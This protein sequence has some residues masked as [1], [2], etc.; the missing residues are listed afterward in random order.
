MKF[1][2]MKKYHC[3]ARRPAVLATLL[4]K[5]PAVLT[6]RRSLKKHQAP[7]AIALKTLSSTA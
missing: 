3:V 7:S 1:Q 4:F 2:V 6:G 5:F